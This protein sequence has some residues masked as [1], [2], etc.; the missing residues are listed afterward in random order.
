MSPL[1]AEQRREVSLCRRSGSLGT[2]SG[3]ND[4]FQVAAA[5]QRAGRQPKASAGQADKADRELAAALALAWQALP[6]EL[7][8]SGVWGQE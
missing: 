2:S 7:Q 3:R 4:P 8:S 5:L 1:V 6:P